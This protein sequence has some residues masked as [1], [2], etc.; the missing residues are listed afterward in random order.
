MGWLP[1]SLI[2]DGGG[3]TPAVLLSAVAAGGWRREEVDLLCIYN[4]TRNVLQ[5]FSSKPIILY[6]K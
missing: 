1:E 3:Q 6:N 5:L 4:F 2:A